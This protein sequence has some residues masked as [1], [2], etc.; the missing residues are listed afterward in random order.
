MTYHNSTPV[1]HQHGF[2]ETGSVI[3]I[4]WHGEV[5]GD[6]LC[7]TIRLVNQT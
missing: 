3:V 2:T 4:M 1:P 5:E 6:I 7:G